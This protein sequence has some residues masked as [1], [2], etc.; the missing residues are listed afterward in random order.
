[1][2]K[3]SSD[4]IVQ[5][6]KEALE[7]RKERKFVESVELQ[8]IL[9]DFNPERE[10]RFNATTVLNS[11]TKSNI[12][13]VVVGTIG[14]IE[15]A[16]KMGIDA[17]SKDDLKKFNNE[18]KLIKKWARK[19][20][21][22]LI[23]DSINREVTKLVGRYITS[24]GKLPSTI[25]EK[26]TVEKKVNELMKTIRFRV[27]K[28]P[29]VAQSIGVANSSLEDLKANLT[30]SINFLIS[31]LPKGW[32]NIKSMTVKTTMGKPQKLF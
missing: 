26:E 11:N 29:W 7:N 14:H 1:M 2:S 21:A 9:R 10:K 24:V 3:V 5:T 8:V 15:Q 6:L 16:K 22:I 27:K 18:A 23:T 4:N 19:Y 12:K 20:D 32:H 13:F 17:I 30:K 31:L 25:N 28:S